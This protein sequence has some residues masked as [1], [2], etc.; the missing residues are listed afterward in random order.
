MPSGHR[1]TVTRSQLHADLYDELAGHRH[2]EHA[3]GMAEAL[4]RHAED[5]YPLVG[6]GADCERAVFFDAAGGTL[7]AREFGKH[8]VGDAVEVA[9][10]VADPDGWVEAAPEPLGWV[11]PRY[12]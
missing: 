6:V 5:D 7:V 4:L 3:R 11:H 8:G 1:R 12:R 2:A 10:D 9:R